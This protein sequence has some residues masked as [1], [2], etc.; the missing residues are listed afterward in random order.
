VRQVCTGL[1]VAFAIGEDGDVFSW[2]NGA[3]LLLGHGD[4]QSQDTQIQSLPKRVEALQGVPVN[5]VAL[6][7][8]HALAWTAD[9]LVYTWG[10][11]K[12][13]ESWATR[14]FG[15]SRC[16]NRSRRSGACAWAASPPTTFAAT[17]WLTRARCGRGDLK[18]ITKPRSATAS[19]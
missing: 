1:D 4:T 9:G 2:G 3:I 11:N 7:R 19:R 10:Q 15:G 13:G 16:R 12:D 5:S 14:M 18:A 6:G 17:Q 8:S